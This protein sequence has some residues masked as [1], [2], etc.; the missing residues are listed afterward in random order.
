[1]R[2]TFAICLSVAI[3]VMLT[4]GIAQAFKVGDGTLEVDSL[5]VGQQGLGGVTYFNGTIINATTDVAGNG[6]PVTFGDDV[7]IDGEIFRGVKND[8]GAVKI[9]DNLEVSGNI[10]GK[11][12]NFKS[13]T[14]NGKDVTAPPKVDL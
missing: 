7:R 2:K 14:V 12:G 13:L 9:S 5:K 11:A 4:A 3:S 10:K 6:M 8:D 1:M